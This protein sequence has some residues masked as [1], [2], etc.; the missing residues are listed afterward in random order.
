[1]TES[2][3]E[4]PIR[5]SGNLIQRVIR[6]IDRILEY[7]EVFI[8]GGSI[9]VMAIVM[10]T[11]VLGRTFFRIG[12]PGVTEITELLIILITFVGVSYAVR[13]ARHISM[14]ALYDQLRGTAR[15]ALLVFICLLT[16]TLLFYLAWEALGYVQT[17]HGRGRTSSAL[18]I[19]LWM[20]YAVLPVGFF[21]AG[22]QYWLTALRNLTTPGVF[23]SF[24]EREVYDEVPTE[25]GGTSTG[26]DQNKQ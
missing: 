5:G 26:S 11:H 10:V 23:R 7:A 2:G 15:K 8:V 21:L 24:T 4:Q 18:N 25:N 22:L 14:S 12:I 13:R 19:P 6:G 3:A 16:G 9:L 1:M 20:I 17:I